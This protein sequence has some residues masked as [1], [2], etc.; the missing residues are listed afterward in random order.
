MMID[1]MSAGH[2]RRHAQ[3]APE[4]NE[5]QSENGYVIIITRPRLDLLLLV[6]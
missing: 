2:L 1:G 5:R 3:P 4:A 6:A